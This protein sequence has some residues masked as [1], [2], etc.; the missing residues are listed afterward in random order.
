MSDVVVGVA[1]SFTFLSGE[2]HPC[3]YQSVKLVHLRAFV[4]NS[5]IFCTNMAHTFEPP[6]RRMSLLRTICE[7]SFFTAFM[8]CM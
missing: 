1:V 6:F 7:A 2:R 3:P 5:K 4:H 8:F